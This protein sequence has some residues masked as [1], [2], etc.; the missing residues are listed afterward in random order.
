MFE[1][2]K[3]F[4]IEIVEQYRRGAYVRDAIIS[5]EDIELYD[6]ARVKTIIAVVVAMRMKVMLR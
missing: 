2:C 5:M 6:S 4:P 1:L 3:H